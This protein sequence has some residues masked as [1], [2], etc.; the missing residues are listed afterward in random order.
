MIALNYNDTTA[1]N[2]ED[3]DCKTAS[4]FSIL[5]WFC[6]IWVLYVFIASG[7]AFLKSHRFIFWL[8]VSQMLNALT[9]IIWSSVFRQLSNIDLYSKI[10][11]LFALYFAFSAESWPLAIMINIATS[12]SQTHINNRCFEVLL[13]LGRQNAVYYLIGFVLPLIGTVLCAMVGGIPDNQGLMISLGRLQIII[14]NVLLSI[15]IVGVFICLIVFFRVENENNY[16]NP[17]YH[18]KYELLADE[19]IIEESEMNFNQ[20]LETD[21][22]Y[23]G[24]PVKNV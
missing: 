24:I 5:T 21:Q 1:L 6:C 13:K 7:R 22:T 2:F 8:I 15:V 19:S 11:V 3:I 9:H 18:K 20:R 14:G 23:K 12:S 16:M 4:G 17:V 10:H